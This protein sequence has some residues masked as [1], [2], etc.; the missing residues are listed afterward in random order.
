MKSPVWG[1]GRN[2][3]HRPPRSPNHASAGSINMRGKRERVMSC[4]CCV[5][6]DLREK[7]NKQQYKN[8]KKLL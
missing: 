6:I 3:K 7:A 4:G 5:V 1:C 2:L 8:I